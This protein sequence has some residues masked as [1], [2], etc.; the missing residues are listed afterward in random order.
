MRRQLARLLLAWFA[1]HH[2]KLPWRGTRDLYRIWVS[3]IML[4]QT[5]VAAVIPYY[6]RFLA[7]FPTAAELAAAKEEQVLRLWEGLGYYRR[8]RQLHAAAQKIAAEHGGQFPSRY[9]QVRALP[10]IGRYTAGAILS[11]GLDRRLPILEANT[12]RLLSRL[13][14]YRGDT[15]GTAGQKFLWAMAEQI[16]PMKNVG[17]FNQAL[18]ELGSQVCTPRQPKCEECPLASLCPTRKLGLQESI[19]APK[20]PKQYEDVVEAV[21]V[22]RR[23]SKV[24]IR[25]RGEDER[26]AGLWDFPR[27]ASAAAAPH[28]QRVKT[29]AANTATL[30]GIAFEDAELLTTLKHGVTRFRITLHCYQAQFAGL[31]PASTRGRLFETPCRVDAAAKLE[32][33]REQAWV[34]VSSLEELPL[35]VTARKIARMLAAN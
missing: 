11:L 24:F 17:Q 4:Q 33:K 28:Q 15:T 3:E 10:G 9:E 27:F 12:V 5:Q 30:T 22:I 14:A 21:V 29:L 13:A 34:K 20:K 8:A 31:A 32:K 1:R 18:M 25:R 35:S 16:L 23:G 2:R 19:P 6:E 7:A 26:W